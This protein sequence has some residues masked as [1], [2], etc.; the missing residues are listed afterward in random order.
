MIVK[1]R[2]RNGAIR[3]IFAYLL[4]A[5]FFVST[6]EAKKPSDAQIAKFKANY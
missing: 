2:R 5:V 4:L 3:I 6:I 1:S